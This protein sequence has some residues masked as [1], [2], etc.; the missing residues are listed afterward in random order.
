MCRW[1]HSFTWARYN[2]HGERE[3]TNMAE[4][5]GVCW[6][7]HF[8]CKAEIT[9]FALGLDSPFS[10]LALGSHNREIRCICVR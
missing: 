2:M 5:S 4:Q 7:A 8:E 10:L 1:I 3:G 6:L 9:N